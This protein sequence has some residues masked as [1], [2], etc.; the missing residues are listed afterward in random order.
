MINNKV[1]NVFKLFLKMW[2]GRSL[3]GDMINEFGRMLDLGQRMFTDITNVL[4][5]GGNVEIIRDDFFH[6]D[7]R[8]NQLEQS[9]RR[10]VIIHLSQQVQA[11]VAPSL[12]MMSVTKDAERIGDY[13]KNIFDVFEAIHLLNEDCEFRSQLIDLKEKINVG[14]TSVKK[15][16]EKSDVKAAKKV[17]RD[18]LVLQ[19]DCDSAVNS[20]LKGDYDTKHTV[21][22]ALLFR[23]FKRILCHQTNIASSLTMPVDKL[24]FHD[25]PLRPKSGKGKSSR[26]TK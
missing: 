4:F 5:E 16:F 9:I 24:D 20:L 22:Y 12:I 26:Q 25:E 8:I 7:Q 3:V 1:D 13:T 6:N 17:I 21:A 14:F 15:A 2:R 11:D 18:Y 19:Q 23:F 10:K